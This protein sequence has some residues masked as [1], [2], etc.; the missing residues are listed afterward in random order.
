MGKMTLENKIKESLKKNLNPKILKIDNIS[1]LHVNH[2]SMIDNTYKETHFKLYIKSK[3]FNKIS[4]I[5]RQKM[6]Y[7][8][9][10]FAFSEELHALEMECLSDIE[11]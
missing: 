9:I 10:N 6:V 8:H 1:H 4:Q 3:I 7:C 2:E 5:K 11:D